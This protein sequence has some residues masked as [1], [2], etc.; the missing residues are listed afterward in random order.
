MR[1]KDRFVAT[2]SHELRTPLT[3]IVGF[4]ESLEAMLA[5]REEPELMELASI[6]TQEGR[7]MAFMV[8]DLLVAARSEMGR[9]KV[10]REE[11]DLAST[12]EEATAAIVD[13]M[14]GKV[15]ALELEECPAIGDPVRI[16]Q[17]IRNL[18]T[19]AAR[20]GGAN[21]RVSTQHRNGWATIEVADDGPPIPTDERER[22]FQPYERSS[23][24]PAHPQSIGLGLSVCRKL[25]RT[26]G[27]DVTYHHDG[28]S[29]FTVSLPRPTVEHRF[30]RPPSRSVA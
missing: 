9:I 23:T 19:N 1:E 28:W 29:R 22:I 24:R 10:R 6:L 11:V 8:E 3:A 21:V 20:Y 4:G 7:N 16:G 14:D 5:T 2:V 12:A 13:Q 30:D 15:P 27:G 17:I 18:L 26:M 25:A